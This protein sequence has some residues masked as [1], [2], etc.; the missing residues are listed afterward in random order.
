VA[1][2]ATGLRVE[3]DLCLDG[4]FEAQGAVRLL[5][6][7]VTGRL[8]LRGG[9]FLNRGGVA[10]AC[11][12]IQ[13]A[14][15]SRLDGD[16]KAHGQVRFMDAHLAKVRGTAPLHGASVTRDARAVRRKALEAGA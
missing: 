16:F 15:E 9:R 8:D 2:A 5:D 7:V 12:R 11:D 10:L 3:G 14:G 4:G 1:L 6:A 13:V